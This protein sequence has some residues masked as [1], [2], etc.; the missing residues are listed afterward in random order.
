MTVSCASFVLFVAFGI[1][2]VL[3]PKILAKAEGNF[4]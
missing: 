2:S 3:S 4:S 1:L